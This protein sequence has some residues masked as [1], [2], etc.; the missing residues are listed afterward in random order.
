LIESL[1]AITTLNIG[2]GT[3]DLLINNFELK[4]ESKN[5]LILILNKEIK[6]EFLDN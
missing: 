1:V 2:Y 6:K 4:T 3:I 5:K